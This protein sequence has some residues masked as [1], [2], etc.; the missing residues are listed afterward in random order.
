[1]PTAAQTHKS[2]TL[3]DRTGTDLSQAEVL[4]IMGLRDTAVLWRW[5]RSG[6]GPPFRRLGRLHSRVSYPR[7][8]FWKWYDQYVFESEDEAS[9]AGCR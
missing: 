3:F 5:R 6:A 7:S 8:T 4:Q 9:A 2:H 1:M